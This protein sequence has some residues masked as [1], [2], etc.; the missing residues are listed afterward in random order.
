MILP[1][2]ILSEK[3]GWRRLLCPLDA[4]HRF[5]AG[6]GFGAS[7]A[8]GRQNHYRQNHWRSHVILDRIILDRMIISE[9]PVKG[10]ESADG[11]LAE[12]A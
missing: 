7:P 6:R 11:G 8:W 12:M 2:M 9:L 3:Y 1:V 5:R 10:T 4:G